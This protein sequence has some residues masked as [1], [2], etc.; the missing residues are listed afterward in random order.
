MKIQSISNY[1]DGGTVGI[2][3]SGVDKILLEELELPITPKYTTE[4]EDIYEVFRN[5]S[6]NSKDKT[7]Y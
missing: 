3:L 6:I 4:S 5:F 7:L 1:R 2:L